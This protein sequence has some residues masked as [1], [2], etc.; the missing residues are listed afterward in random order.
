MGNLV[1]MCVYFICLGSR[2]YSSAALNEFD[3][4]FAEYKHVTWATKR[5]EKKK[6][7]DIEKYF[8]NLA[9]LLIKEG[10]EK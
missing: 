1:F 7:S 2:L 9:T 4:A 5:R 10:E 6:S 3:D 8:E